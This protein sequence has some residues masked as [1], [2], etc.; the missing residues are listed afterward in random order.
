M[1]ASFF[2]ISPSYIYEN[3]KYNF[4]CVISVYKFF[5]I[6]VLF[7]YIFR[8]SITMLYIMSYK[9]IIIIIKNI[10]M[11]ITIIIGATIIIKSIIIIEQDYYQFII[12][13]SHHH[14]ITII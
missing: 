2:S 9:I 1:R 6:Y 5:I 11:G 8:F 4:S 3:Q 7:S 14:V 10:V 12:I 13:I